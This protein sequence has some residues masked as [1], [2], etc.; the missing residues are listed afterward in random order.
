MAEWNQCYYCGCVLHRRGITFDHVIPKSCGGDKLVS[1]CKACNNLKGESSLGE[2]REY[3]Q[4]EAFYG[5][6]HGWQPW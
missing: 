4:I 2:F 3:L 6:M 1:A 5:E